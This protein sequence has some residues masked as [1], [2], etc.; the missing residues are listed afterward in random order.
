[1]DRE[2][3][4]EKT[5]SILKNA[6]RLRIEYETASATASELD[7]E[8]IQKRL[9]HICK[10][11]N[12][13]I[14][15]LLLLQHPYNDLEDEIS[16]TISGETY[17]ITKM[18][19][20]SIFKNN[21]EEVLSKC[22]IIIPSDEIKENSI[23]DKEEAATDESEA[24]KT[25]SN[26][27][28]A[29]S[30]QESD[31]ADIQQVQN[32]EK[33]IMD[34]P[35]LFKFGLQETETASASEPA[36]IENHT[37]L[38]KKNPDDKTFIQEDNR[39]E[40][41]KKEETKK[42]STS[43]KNEDDI[44]DMDF[45]SQFFDEPINT[46]EDSA[47]EVKEPETEDAISEIKTQENSASESKNAS[48]KTEAVNKPNDEF[49]EPVFDLNRYKENTTEP[50]SESATKSTPIQESEIKEQKS[51]EKTNE[52]KD[53]DDAPMDFD[54]DA[55][56][57]LS[58][59]PK[60]R[61]KTEEAHDQ[62]EPIVHEEESQ[63][64]NMPNNFIFEEKETSTPAHE[65][66]INLTYESK[67]SVENN[68]SNEDLIYVPE[69]HKEAKEKP[70]EKKGTHTEYM[71]GGPEEKIVP[72]MLNFKEEDDDGI[73]LDINRPNGNKEPVRDENKKETLSLI[74][75]LK[76][77]RQEYDK[78]QQQE[79]IMQAQ[80]DEPDDGEYF[81]L[82]TGKMNSGSIQDDDALGKISK[83]AEGIIET[84][85]KDR[86]MDMQLNLGYHATDNGGTYKLQSSSDY[87]REMNH[88][89]LD[90]YSIEVEILDENEKVQ[91]KEYCSLLAAPIAIP[92]TGSSLVTDICACLR[93]EGNT[94][95]AVVVPG[96][97]TT[98]IFRDENY[99]VFVRG[100]WENGEFKTNISVMGNGTNIKASFK[101]KEF[102]PESMTNMGIGHNV[103]YV[104]HVTTVHI[105][106]LTFENTLFG[107]SEI[108]AIICRDYGVDQDAECMITKGKPDLLIKGEKYKYTLTGKW[109]D[110]ILKVDLSVTK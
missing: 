82:S 47:V 85:K 52:K 48:S 62:S 8:E 45:F 16:L 100:A 5:L 101:K 51:E 18:A 53:L 29:E 3:I 73:D 104:D 24:S 59:D 26:N 76:K 97:K 72:G 102:R 84:S 57:N 56:F 9:R 92:E 1:M 11:K 32:K 19:L 60:S 55:L 95:A 89:V 67:E 68:T 80:E 66:D 75:K 35:L 77:N 41:N 25:G 65:P 31:A 20:K 110:N 44:M 6:E 86:V 13:S 30:K 70:I 87:E 23:T 63:K 81:D 96:G 91:A 54:L 17:N 49:D 71:I 109:D 42:E 83:V 50:A 99:A 69:E 7:R 106:P 34:D 105:I 103:L 2:H 28:I 46:K 33:D 12:C 43:S 4:K 90:L 88:F 21:L 40:E 61:K 74:E 14:G 15:T 22:P 108:M 36:S 93:N 10:I 37:E 39:P 78:I 58:G 27:E 79:Q 64:H 107:Y 98:L 38:D 94:E